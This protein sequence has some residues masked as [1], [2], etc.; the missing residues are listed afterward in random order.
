MSQLIANTKSLK[1]GL[2]GYAG[3]NSDAIV[4]YRQQPSHMSVVSDVG[5]SKKL[6][7]VWSGDVEI[8]AATNDRNHFQITYSGVP[9]Q[10]CVQMGTKL[11]GISLRSISINSTEVKGQG[12]SSI[13]DACS[14]LGDKPVAFATVQ[15]TSE[16]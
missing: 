1:D 7:N 14:V 2:N 8:S 16:S 13:A 5:G 9:I 11:Q 15:V 4:R 6:M 10:A 3:L 12:I